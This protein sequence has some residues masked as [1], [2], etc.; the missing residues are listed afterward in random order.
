MVKNISL[1]LSGGAARGYAHIGVI[2]VLEKYGYKIKSISGTSIG[3]LIGGFYAAGALDVYEEWVTNL[4]KMDLVKL[5]DFSLLDNGVIKGEKLFAVL[6]TMV[7]DVNIEELPIKY[8]AVATDITAKREMWFQKGNLLQAIRASIAIP[9]VFTPI[10]IGSHYFVDG[11][12][13]NSLPITPVMS[14]MNN[15]IV[16]VYLNA[17]IPNKYTVKLSDEDLQRQNSIKSY[18]LELWKKSRNPLKNHKYNDIFYI[19]NISMVM[20]QNLITRYKMAECQPDII[21]NIPRESCELYDFHKAKE[22]IK[23]GEMA[24]ED[25]LSSLKKPHQSS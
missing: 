11:G 12:V 20:M 7:K 3:S 22:M 24:A 16:A 9:S 5:L 13:L 10:Q 6:K 4:T 2:R 19:A 15:L 25:V 18:F 8:T 17:D 21:I 23:I 1:V 14:D